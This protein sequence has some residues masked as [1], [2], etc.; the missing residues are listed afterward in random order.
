MPKLPAISGKNLLRALVR[1]GYIP[2]RTKGSHVFVEDRVRKLATVIPI[3]HNED[4]GKGLFKSI[5][6]DLDLS[7]EDILKIL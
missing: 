1:A 4:L 7:G 3:H 6:K 5:L 2:V